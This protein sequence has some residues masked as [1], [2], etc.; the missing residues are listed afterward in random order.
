MIDWGNHSRLVNDIARNRCVIY[1][2]AG[3]SRNSVNHEGK[4]PPVWREFL[5]NGLS[6]VDEPMQAI[7]NDKIQK[8]NYLL[9]CELL[10]RSISQE[11]FNDLLR[12]NFLEPQFEK[13]QIH[14]CIL[15]LDPKI[16][17]TPNFDK[18]YDLY[19]QHTTNGTTFVKNYYDKDIAD[20]IRDS[21]PLIIKMHGTVDTPDK[22]IFTQQEYAKSR[23]EYA[24][25]YILINALLVTNTFLFIGAGI[26]DPD[27][28]L[29]LENHNYTFHYSHRH[30]FLIGKDALSDAEMD[31]Y[32]ESM[33]L[34]FITYDTAN[35]H[36]ELTDSLEHLVSLVEDEKEHG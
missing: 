5:E 11:R 10:K 7:I 36:Q 21:M 4:H 3:V 22:L 26:N 6:I 2:G 23:V 24:D 27:I 19:V 30:Y 29:L 12:T 8:E 33:N 32:G 20:I 31:I 28:R 18:I 15:G 34:K 14:E 13:A 9:A 16:V 25:F 1:L 17:L 35:N